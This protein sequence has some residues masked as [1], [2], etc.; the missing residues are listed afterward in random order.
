MLLIIEPI[1]K[2]YEEDNDLM[3]KLRPI[4]QPE[5]ILMPFNRLMEKKLRKT[6]DGG[7]LGDLQMSIWKLS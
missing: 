4:V 7:D 3:L 2:F 1:V 6:L 5:R